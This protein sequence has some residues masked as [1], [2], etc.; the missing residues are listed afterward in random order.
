MQHPDAALR[1]GAAGRRW[2]ADT[3]SPDRFVEE[4]LTVIEEALGKGRAA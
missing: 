4:I 1:M 3:F 2:A